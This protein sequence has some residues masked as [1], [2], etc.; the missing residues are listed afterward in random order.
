MLYLSM[1]VVEITE[2][3]AM[4]TVG[5]LLSLLL[6]VLLFLEV[7]DISSGKRD[8]KQ[9]YWMK[10]VLPVKEECLYKKTQT[11]IIEKK[12]NQENFFIL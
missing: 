11:I 3:E 9:N 12:K 5:L 4:T 8:N 7:L 6:E 10:M 2:E 1:E